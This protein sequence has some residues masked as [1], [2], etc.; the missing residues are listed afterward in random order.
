MTTE[1]PEEY[2]SPRYMVWQAGYNAGAS[3]EAKVRKGEGIDKFQAGVRQG[4]SL[5]ADGIA[6]ALILL[7]QEYGS[8]KY[9][10]TSHDMDELNRVSDQ[11]RDTVASI[12]TLR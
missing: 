7:A 11:L 5:A 9:V 8:D 1:N 4:R 2:T 12:E 3:D 10:F 6:E